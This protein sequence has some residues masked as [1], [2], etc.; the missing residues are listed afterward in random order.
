MTASRKGLSLY[1]GVK[2]IV[3]INMEIVLVN[4]PTILLKPIHFV[5][6]MIDTILH[7]MIE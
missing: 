4:I 2:R 5:L 7:P 6:F 1:N 3:N